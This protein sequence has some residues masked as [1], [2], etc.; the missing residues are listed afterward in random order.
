MA[1]AA[2]DAAAA[3][4]GTLANHDQVK[5][6]TDLPKFTGQSGADSI[7]PQILV[8]RI[9]AAAVIANWD[10]ARKIRELYMTLRGTAITFWDTMLDHD[11]DT[12][13]WANVKAHFL[14]CYDSRTTARTTCA[15]FQDLIQ[16]NGEAVHDYYLRV[17]V[18]HKKMVGSIPDTTKTLKADHLP[19]EAAVARTFKDEGIRDIHLFYKHQLFI[20]GLKDSLRAKV[21]EA[22]KTTMLDSMLYARE[23]ETIQADQKKAQIHAIQIPE[24]NRIENTLDEEEIEAINALRFRRQQTPFRGSGQRSRGSSRGQYQ[25][26][27]IGRAHV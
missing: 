19:A 22:G 17:H 10:E 1:A 2:N 27:E 24:E 12:T 20:A 16:R 7:N 23:M 5:K 25:N 3:M 26:T 14:L 11:I 15:N 13:V 18:A 4:Q 8:D 9:D 21:M 6:S